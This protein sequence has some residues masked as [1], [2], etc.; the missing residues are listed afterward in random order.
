MVLKITAVMAQGVS[1]DRF[2]N[3]L[4]CAAQS[5]KSLL[6]DYDV[7]VTVVGPCIC[8]SSSS[9]EVGRGL[10]RLVSECV[11]LTKYPFMDADGMLYP[12]FASLMKE[13]EV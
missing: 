1:Q 6:Y 5:I 12:E 13:G 11:E 4:D 9:A 10:P 8:V 3:A 7:L 2:Q